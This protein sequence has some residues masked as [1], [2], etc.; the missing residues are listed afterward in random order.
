MHAILLHS[1]ALQASMLWRSA[2]D[3]AEELAWMCLQSSLQVSLRYSAIHS[4]YQNSP[5]LAALQSTC[6]GPPGSLFPYLQLELYSLT[7]A[8]KRY[9]RGHSCIALPHS[10]PS[11]ARSTAAGVEMSLHGVGQS[12]TG[13]I[14]LTQGQC[15]GAP[16]SAAAH[17]PS[18]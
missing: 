3:Q 1:A 12:P 6:Q 17:A 18:R 8:Q 10:A 15:P 11:L 14:V 5:M 4:L 13:A 16:Q 7:I 9:H 2:T